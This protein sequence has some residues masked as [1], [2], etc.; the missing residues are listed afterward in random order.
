[1]HLVV[2]QIWS[3]LSMQPLPK[4]INCDQTFLL[5]HT[6]VFSLVMRLYRPQYTD[7]VCCQSPSSCTSFLGMSL[8][9]VTRMNHCISFNTAW[10]NFNCGFRSSLLR[11]IETSFSLARW[12]RCDKATPSSRKFHN[13]QAE[14]D[15]LHIAEKECN[16]WAIEQMKRL[17]AMHKHVWA[18]CDMQT[19]RW[20]QAD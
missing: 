15:T 3:P 17:F 16:S 14:A 1:M 6:W 2:C 11:Y 8:S 13:N 10:P 19:C 12:D 7:R 5:R 20:W 4:S 18:S 9:N